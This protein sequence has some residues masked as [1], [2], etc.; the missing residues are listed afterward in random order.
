MLSDRLEKRGR[1][2]KEADKVTAETV[3]GEMQQKGREGETIGEHSKG[4][5]AG[6][7]NRRKAAVV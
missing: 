3:T 6:N 5:R 7:G 1:N 4:C 2:R